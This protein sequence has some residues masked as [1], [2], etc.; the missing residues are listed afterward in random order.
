[1]KTEQ[2]IN[3]M[4]DRVDVDKLN[5]RYF[6]SGYGAGCEETFLWL[7]GEISDEDFKAILNT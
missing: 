1:M 6:G 7:I 3:E 4:F 2:E 5:A